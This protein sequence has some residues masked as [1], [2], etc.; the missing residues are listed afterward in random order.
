MVVHTLTLT[1]GIQPS[2][3]QQDAVMMSGQRSFARMPKAYSVDLKCWIVRSALYS[4]LPIEEV[5]QMFL[6]SEKTANRAVK[7][8]FATGTYVVSGLTCGR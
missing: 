3:T 1:I 5:T 6:V 7:W 2:Q 4:G 8:C